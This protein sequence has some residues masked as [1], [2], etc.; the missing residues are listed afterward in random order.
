MTFSVMTVTTVAR[1]ISSVAFSQSGRVI[2]IKVASNPQ[3][4]PARTVE[5]TFR[6]WLR[7]LE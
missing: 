7:P 6:A 3:R 5:W 1:S 4:T 2:T